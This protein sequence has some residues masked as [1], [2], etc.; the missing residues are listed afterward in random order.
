MNIDINLL[1]GP[2]WHFQVF[3]EGNIHYTYKFFQNMPSNYMTGRKPNAHQ[4]VPCEAYHV[5]LFKGLS[6]SNQKKKT[7]PHLNLGRT[8]KQ[9]CE[10]KKK[11]N[12]KVDTVWWLFGIYSRNNYVTKKYLLKTY[13]AVWLYLIFKT[14]EDLVRKGY[15]ELD[16]DS[17][18]SYT[19]VYVCES[20]NEEAGKVKRWF[21][22]FLPKHEELSADLQ[23]PS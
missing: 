6:L 16:F 13:M 12:K 20:L 15:L 3:T 10:W 9:H 21:R 5:Y 14:I 18:S 19:D 7:L 11:P 4:Q 1:C 8:R 2:K 17:D 23:H 22:S